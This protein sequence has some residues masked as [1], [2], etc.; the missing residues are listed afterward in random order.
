MKSKL[1][2]VPRPK[3]WTPL[4]G[5]VGKLGVE[6]DE[7]HCQTCVTLIIAVVAL[8]LAAVAIARTL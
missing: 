5:E 7:I 4:H 6:V 2:I 1:P 3:W 8:I